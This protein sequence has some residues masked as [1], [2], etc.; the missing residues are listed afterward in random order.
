MAELKQLDLLDAV[1]ARDHGLEINLH[2]RIRGAPAKQT[3]RVSRE[4]G[5]RHKGRQAGNDQDRDRPW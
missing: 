2:P 1:F 4:L 3:E 5:L